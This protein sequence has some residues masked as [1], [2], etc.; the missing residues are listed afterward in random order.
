[1]IASHNHS[2]RKHSGSVTPITVFHMARRL[3]VTTGVAF[4]NLSQPITISG[5]AEP[6]NGMNA[7]KETTF[8]GFILLQRLSDSGY[9]AY[10]V[11]TSSQSG[12]SVGQIGRGV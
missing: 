2:G 1:M 5:I 10:S 3:P 4:A 9:L 8:S 12:T 6:L 11:F 7:L